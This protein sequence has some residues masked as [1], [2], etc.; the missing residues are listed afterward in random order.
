MVPAV[1]AAAA[2]AIQAGGSVLNS[3]GGIISQNSAN[4]ANVKMTRET[5][6]MN[7]KIAQEANA[8]NQQLQRDQNAWNLAQWNRENDYNSALNQRK[9][10]ELAGLNPYYALNEIAKGSATSNPLESA[11]YTPTITP[12]MQAPSVQPISALGTIGNAAGDFVNT[13]MNAQMNAANVT[14]AQ[15]DA[16]SSMADAD[17]K[18]AEAAAIS[19][20]QKHYYN[21]MTDTQ[22]TLQKLYEAQTRM[23]TI[24]AN[25]KDL[26]GGKIAEQEYLSKVQQILKSK[27]DVLVN[28]AQVRK[29]IS[30]V[31]VNYATA[32]NLNVNSNLISKTTQLTIDKMKL[33]NDAQ[34]SMNVGL[35]IDAQWQKKWGFKRNDLGY[36]SLQ[37]DVDTKKQQQ[38]LLRKE[39]SVYYLK[40]GLDALSSLTSSWSNIIKPSELPSSPVKVAGFGR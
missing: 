10:L 1:P 27:S 14:K 9:R 18:A 12:T 33:A 26:W 17:K 29:I 15:A 40:F 13:Y 20:Y 23:N 30:D 16:K 35:D 8:N 28:D 3:I 36:Q 34:E 4:H 7:Y 24:D 2:A 6:A 5:N 38:K 39:N 37:T 11:P 32:H 25:I 21:S 31:L 19:G 22:K